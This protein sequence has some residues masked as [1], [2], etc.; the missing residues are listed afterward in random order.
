MQAQTAVLCCPPFALSFINQLMVRPG[1]LC[2]NSRLDPKYRLQTQL[3]VFAFALSR[4]NV[5][6]A[7]VWL[8]RRLPFK[9]GTTPPPLHITTANLCPLMFTTF[10]SSNVTGWHPFNQKGKTN[11]CVHSRSFDCFGVKK[12]ETFHDTTTTSPLLLTMFYS[13]SQVFILPL[14]LSLDSSRIK[15][16]V[17]RI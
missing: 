5:Q 7:V 2:W 13:E 1:D 4:I 11:N 3:G 16:A 6:Q 14:D 9:C 8:K 15:G 10:I 17:C 12:K